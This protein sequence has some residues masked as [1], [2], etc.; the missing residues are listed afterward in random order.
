VVR[1]VNHRNGISCP[2]LSGTDDSQVGPRYSASGERE[3]PSFAF[4]PRGERATRGPGSADLQHQL[5]PD[6]PPLA[7]R[8]PVTSTP[9]SIRFSPKIPERLSMPL[10][11][12]RANMGRSVCRL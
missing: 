1:P 3:D 2:D 4:H 7:D 6:A 12:V 8:G 5:R 9:T 11:P 10:C